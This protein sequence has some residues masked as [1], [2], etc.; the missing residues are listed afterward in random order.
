[1]ST[2]DRAV[3]ADTAQQYAEARTLYLHTLQEGL[4][5]YQRQTDTNVQRKLLGKLQ[6]VLRRVQQLTGVTQAADIEDVPHSPDREDGSLQFGVR[7]RPHETFANVIGLEHAKQALN[8]LLI[9]SILHPHVRPTATGCE[10]ILLYGPPGTGK[11]HLARAAAGQFNCTFLKVT[12]ADIHNKYVGESEKQ[13]KLLFAEA[14]ANAPTIVF[15]DEF[16]ALS[17]VRDGA[18][19]ATS[20]VVNQLLQEI[21]GLERTT[22]CVVVLAATNR[23]DRID[24]ATLDRFRTH[25]HVPLPSTSDRAKIFL[26]ELNDTDITAHDCVAFARAT[27]GMSGRNIHNIVKT[28]SE[29]PMNEAVTATHFVQLPPTDDDERWCA[30][31]S[32]AHGAVPMTILDVPRGTLQLRSV[33]AEDVFAVLNMAA[34]TPS[35]PCAPYPDSSSDELDEASADGPINVSTGGLDEPL[36]RTPL[37][38]DEK[39]G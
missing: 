31:S 34:P 27:D 15:V 38:N 37:G 21:D 30:C 5:E 23:L 28:A 4:R 16:D 22:D 33:S 25:I 3:A 32:T 10:G 14:R 20:S 36:E 35:V 13:L 29:R 17:P 8:N 2:L 19:Q 24:S 1:M 6:E 26:Q 39:L 12:G 11:T 9:F 18:T 7:T